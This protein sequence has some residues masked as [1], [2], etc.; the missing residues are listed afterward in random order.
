MEAG[1]FFGGTPFKKGNPKENRPYLGP[2]NDVHMAAGLKVK[3]NSG[4]GRRKG[5]WLEFCQDEHIEGDASGM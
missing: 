1:V 4:S 5:K 3:V 2:L